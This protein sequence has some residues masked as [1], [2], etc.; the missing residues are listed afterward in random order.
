L[1]E[2]AD[3]LGFYASLKSTEE[4]VKDATDVTCMWARRPC[5]NDYPYGDVIAIASTRVGCE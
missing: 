2:G 4:S 5:P 3:N 1:I